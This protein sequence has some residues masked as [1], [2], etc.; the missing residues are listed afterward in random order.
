MSA[1]AGGRYALEMPA[2]PSSTNLF[3][4]ALGETGTGKEGPRTVVKNVLKIAG[5]NK[6]ETSAAS[7]VGLLK[8]LSVKR[9]AI[10][11]NDEFGR[12]LKSAANPNGGHQFALISQV[13]KL[14]GLALSST[15]ERS[16]ADSKKSLPAIERPYLS[17][18]A[19]TTGKS[20]TDAMSSEEIVG[21]TLNRFIV[22]SNGDPEPPFRNGKTAEMSAKLK[23]GIKRFS[24][25]AVPSNV[26]PDEGPNNPVG[27]RVERHI[28]ITP[29]DDAVEALIAYR[30]EAD[31]KRA[32]AGGAA[33]H[34]WARS[35]ENALRVAG[36]VAIGDSDPR[37]PILTLENAL[38]AITFMRWSSMGTIPPR[39]LPTGAT[40]V[41]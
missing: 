5:N 4:I 25:N 7:D 8:K 3:I 20:V 1:L 37:N 35:Y 27:F 36:C 39:Q 24:E 2:G 40:S 15:E 9:D 18:L 28:S 29:T 32:K 19:T 30:D 41:T 10:W 16:Y 12:Y 14:Y 6:A 38:W 34:L 26:V 21:G 11:I 13:M 23:S 33:A 31:A 17:V 22:I